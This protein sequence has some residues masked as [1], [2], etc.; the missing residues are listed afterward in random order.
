MIDPVPEDFHTITLSSWSTASAG[1]S[2]GIRVRSAHTS[3]SGTWRLTARPSCT[4]S[5][6][7]ETHAS[8]SS[9]NFRG[10]WP[11]RRPWATAVTL[12]LYAGRRRALRP[13]RRRR[14]DSGHAGR[15]SVLGRQYILKIP[16]D[17]VGR[18]RAASRTSHRGRFSNAR[19][20]GRRSSSS[21]E[22]VSHRA[23]DLCGVRRIAVLAGV[24]HGFVLAADYAPYT[25]ACSDRWTAACSVHTTAARRALRVHLRPHVGLHAL[26]ATRLR[27]SHART[28]ARR[29]RVD[30]G[31]GPP[32]AHSTCE[33]PWPGSLVVKQLGLELVSSIA[34]GLVAFIA[35]QQRTCVSSDVRMSPAE[36]NA[37]AR[38][39]SR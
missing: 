21:H 2:S 3:F 12:H 15:G 25:A 33:Q 30:D 17:I 38:L 5:C 24:I 35:R 28:H 39:S 11:R 18:W 14:R 26:T 6:C 7:W 10:R 22:D 19:R 23:V 27:C 34:I 9:T 29:P 32:L 1:Q 16:T 37:A 31:T 13:R 4:P 8:S 36:D 20:I